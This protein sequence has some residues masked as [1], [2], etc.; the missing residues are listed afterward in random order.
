VGIWSH[1]LNV[2]KIGSLIINLMNDKCHPSNTILCSRGPGKSSFRR[3]PPRSSPPENRTQL[4]PVPP[5]RATNPSGSCLRRVR[6]A[7]ETER[8]RIDTKR[9][10]WSLDLDS[11]STLLTI[12]ANV[13]AGRR[14]WSCAQVL[15]KTRRL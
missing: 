6:C 8:H 11:S 3:T 14:N 7:V 5:G 10:Y 15:I 2:T 13:Q 9:V 12:D 1:V 4:A